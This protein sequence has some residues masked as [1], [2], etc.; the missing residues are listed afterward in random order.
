MSRTPGRI[1]HTGPP[2]GSDTG[3]V[4]NELGFSQAEI[5]A[6]DRD[7]AWGVSRD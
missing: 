1:A 3:D 6:G 4:L 2:L 5:A 7:G